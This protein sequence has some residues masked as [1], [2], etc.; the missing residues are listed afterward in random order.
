MVR[1]IPP[2]PDHGPDLRA[3]R[4]IP[5][6][7][8]RPWMIGA[9]LLALALHGALL[10]LL[11]T[12]PPRPPHAPPPS[13]SVELIVQNSPTVGAPPRPA[14]PAPRPRP[15]LP[16][17]PKPIAPPPR[18]PVHAPTVPS[19]PPAAPRPLPPHPTVSRPAAPPRPAPPV[20]PTAVHLGPLRTPGTGIV[21]G[22][23]V[24]PA[25][26]T[27]PIFN[28]PPGYPRAA[29]RLGQSGTVR[30]LIH[31]AADGRATAVDITR[32]S[33]YPLLDRAARRALLRWRF[34]AARTDGHAVASTLPWRVEFTL[35]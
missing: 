5:V 22:P 24:I 3:T 14:R 33:G 18:P 32:S 2:R 6:A 11:L 7:P 4:L 1:A 8:R 26:P 10:A 15:P 25:R 9:A 28:S 16:I 35:R 17:P 12:H 19:P 34:V 29:A 21:T 27:A 31:V 13:P 20:P 30:L 23:Y